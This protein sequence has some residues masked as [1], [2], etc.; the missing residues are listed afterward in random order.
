MALIDLDIP[1]LKEYV[2]TSIE[3]RHSSDPSKVHKTE[4]SL[5]DYIKNI[6]ATGFSK[7]LQLGETKF[8]GINEN[9]YTYP[10]QFQTEFTQLGIQDVF[11]NKDA[12][13]FT[14]KQVSPQFTGIVKNNYLYPNS[15]GLDLG[16][17]GIQI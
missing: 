14:K 10:K 15:Q 13:G 4:L 7:N 3:R 12:T 6:F 11:H 17:L 1:K 8:V 2:K 9:I 5:V 16:I